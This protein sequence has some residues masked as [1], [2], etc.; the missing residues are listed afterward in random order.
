[1][2]E[3][4]RLFFKTNQ[5]YTTQVIINGEYVFVKELSIKQIEKLQELLESFEKEV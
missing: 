4:E 2:D 5:K 1:M 3:L